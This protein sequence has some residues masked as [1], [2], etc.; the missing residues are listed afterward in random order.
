MS[1]DSEVVTKMGGSVLSYQ[2]GGETNTSNLAESGVRPETQ[3]KAGG[4]TY[5]IN[6]GDGG[7]VTEKVHASIQT[8][9]N[10]PQFSN[11]GES[12]VATM[13]TTGGSK[14]IN[15]KSSDQLLVTTPEGTMSVSTAMVLGHV[16]QDVNG[17][18]L[19]ATPTEENSV[20]KAEIDSA[21]H[22]DADIESNI[23]AL[24]S[25]LGD[26]RML[27]IIS[28]IATRTSADEEGAMGLQLDLNGLTNEQSSRACETIEQ[29]MPALEEQ[30]RGF[31]MYENDFSEADAD[32]FSDWFWSK[33]SV[34]KDMRVS[35]I[36]KHFSGG[37]LSGYREMIQEFRFHQR[38]K[39]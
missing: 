13:T 26:S 7:G 27:N 19:D 21:G 34:A 17:N 28:Q 24:S 32:E 5:S 23:S 11:K 29:A 20:G 33:E 6:V 15:G 22:L 2:V 38:H 35:S 16:T 31:L 37:D 25:E 14:N 3:L 36:I 12:T 9:E 1:E 4:K 39:K 18:Y 30:A 8:G 10:I